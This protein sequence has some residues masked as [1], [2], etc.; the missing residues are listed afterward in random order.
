MRSRGRGAAV[1]LGH[2]LGEGIHGGTLAAAARDG[3]IC[4][5]CKP[6]CDVFGVA[7]VPAGLAPGKG[8]PEGGD[9]PAALPGALR[10]EHQSG[11]RAHRE[12]A[13]GATRQVLAALW[14]R[15]HL[16]GSLGVGLPRE[17]GDG[18]HVGV[19]LAVVASHGGAVANPRGETL[20]TTRYT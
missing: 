14:A 11:V 5:L 13:D 18:A 6:V 4:V 2:D 12:E 19:A 10:A 3:A 1:I 15:L 8:R 16:D 7:A 20:G 17:G 9:P